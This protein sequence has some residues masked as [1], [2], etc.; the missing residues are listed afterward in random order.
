MEIP[1]AA[2]VVSVLVTVGFGWRLDWSL[3]RFWSCLVLI[4]VLLPGG[5]VAR[6]GGRY[7]GSDLVIKMNKR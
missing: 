3:G 5:N 1:S 4:L 6:L 7:T 2:I